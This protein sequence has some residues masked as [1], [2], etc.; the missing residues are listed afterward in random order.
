MVNRN[1]LNRPLT[2]LSTPIFQWIY[3]HTIDLL[4]QPKKWSVER[5][6]YASSKWCSDLMVFKISLA[7]IVSLKIISGGDH[8]WPAW[9]SAPRPS[10]QHSGWVIRVSSGLLHIT[11]QNMETFSLLL[12]LCMGI[13][14]SPVDF[15]DKI[16]IMQRFDVP[17]DVG[18]R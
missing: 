18:S 4:R 16:P 6:Q 9:V 12:C 1:G 8:P 11:R 2:S 10:S 3:Q 13:H 14:Q 17:V 5:L 7:Q 15:P